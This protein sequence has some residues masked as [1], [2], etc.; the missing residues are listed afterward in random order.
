VR[1]WSPSTHSLSAALLQVPVGNTCPPCFTTLLPLFASSYRR[2][3][4]ICFHATPLRFNP[5]MLLHPPTSST[6]TC[7]PTHPSL[8]PPIPTHPR[9]PLPQHMYWGWR[10]SLALAAIPGFILFIGALCLPDTPNSLIERG[11]LERGEKVLQRVRGVKGETQG[12]GIGDKEGGRSGWRARKGAGRCRG[13]QQE[14]G[15]KVH[16]GVCAASRMRPGGKGKRE[17]TANLVLQ[18]YPFL[19][20][21][22]LAPIGSLV[23]RHNPMW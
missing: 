1:C 22:L 2:V 19:S 18:A 16:G 21:S 3:R 11:K 20:C 5:L 10:L 14:D 12:Q 7:P 15:C 4:Q 13:V 23:V 8:P 17:R 9:P 6:P